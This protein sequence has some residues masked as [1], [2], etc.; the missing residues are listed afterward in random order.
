[1]QERELLLKEVNHRIKNSL[2][3]VSGMLHLQLPLI[4]DPTAA[5]ALRG[6]EARV[7]AIAAVHDHFYKDDDI[8]SI[9]LDKF[10]ADLCGDIA[11]AYGAINGVAVEAQP[12]EI[13]KDEA[14]SIALIVNELVTNAFRHG[15]PPCKITLHDGVADGLKLTV[16][17]S[18][19]GPTPGRTSEG[20]GTRIVNSLVQ[21]LGGTLSGKVD[22]DGYRCE[23]Y[24][25]HR[26]QGTL[27]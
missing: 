17:D 21:Q 23:L 15:G 13:G 7:R 2:Q 12:L 10:L 6:T 16:A 27:S 20:L 5:D 18:G 14:I 1:V 4:K 19:A 24:V 25:P 11:R 3:I 9:R 26:P 22:S 8:Q